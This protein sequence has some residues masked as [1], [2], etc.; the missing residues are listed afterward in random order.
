MPRFFFPQP[1]FAPSIWIVMSLLNEHL[2]RDNST[3][4]LTLKYRSISPKSRQ[5]S[6]DQTPI[7]K[8]TA[9]ITSSP[10]DSIQSENIQGNVVGKVKSSHE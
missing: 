4:P 2:N 5:H 9:N 3:A 8:K 6:S 7:A 1:V 10:N